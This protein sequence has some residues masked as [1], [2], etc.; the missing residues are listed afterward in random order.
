MAVGCAF[1]LL[2]M[3]VLAV[4][5]ADGSFGLEGIALLIFLIVFLGSGMRL[6][7][8]GV[9]IFLQDKKR[10]DDLREAYENNR[11]VMADIV[12]VRAMTFST[13]TSDNIFTGVCYREYYL[14]ECR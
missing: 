4:N 3:T 7:F 6:L 14:V 2:G 10:V 11:C 5:Q 9:R 13:R 1:T 8:A 12:D